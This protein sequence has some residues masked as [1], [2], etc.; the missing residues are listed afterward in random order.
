MTPYDGFT[1]AFRAAG[2]P[3]GLLHAIKERVHG[4]EADQAVGDL[5]TATDLLDGDSLGRERFV[6]SLFAVFAFLALAF[7]V[8][9]LY[10]I[11]SYLVAQRMRELGV[12]IALGARQSHI[13]D[14]VIR[15][16]V[17]SV[18]V[19]AG[20]GV[21]ANLGWSRLLA[22]WTNGNARDPEM[23]TIVVGLLLLTTAAASLGP[24]L[25]AISIDPVRALRSE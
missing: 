2:N 10:S 4:V 15:P 3:A 6:A 23:L 12:R 8:S 16:S 9:G 20:I 22:H 11:E 7:A 25:A 14:E 13:A 5:T 1:I 21:V 24:V 17:L 18:F 19:G